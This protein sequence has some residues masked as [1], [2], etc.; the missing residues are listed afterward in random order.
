MSFRKS[1]VIALKNL[2]SSNKS[3][4]GKW[5]WRYQNEQEALCRA[6]IKLKYGTMGRMVFESRVEKN[7]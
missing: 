3:M 7:N 6:V 5:Q 4:L 1:I 2:Q